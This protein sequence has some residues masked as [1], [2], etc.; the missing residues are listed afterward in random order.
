M[1]G[2]EGI[3]YEQRFVP[4]MDFLGG[5]ALSAGALAAFTWFGLQSVWPIFLL[6]AISSAAVAFDN[7]ARQALLLML[8]P[9]ETFPNAVSLGLIAFHVS[10]VVGPALA[11]IILSEVGPALVYGLNTISFVAVI[12]AVFLMRT[13]GRAGTES[14]ENI[15]PSLA[16]LKEGLLFVRST[17]IIVQ[18]MTL[19]FVATFFASATALLPIFAV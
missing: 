3:T 19:D 8:V 6:T 7:P 16:A 18:T 12:T 14:T 4:G 11:G 1:T 2:I 10:M 13:S 9:A 17:P 5:I 15:R